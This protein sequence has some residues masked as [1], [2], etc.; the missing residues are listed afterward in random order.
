[1]TEIKLTKSAKAVLRYYLELN[2][3]RFCLSLETIADAS[4]GRSSNGKPRVKTVQRANE[5]LRRRGLLAWIRGHGP[6]NGGF[7]AKPNEYRLEPLVLRVYRRKTRKRAQ[8]AREHTTNA[9]IQV[10]G[11]RDRA[12]GSE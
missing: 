8:Q 12:Q 4:L 10:S 11:I 1:M 7:P 6:G 2:Q 9:G 5:R 3:E